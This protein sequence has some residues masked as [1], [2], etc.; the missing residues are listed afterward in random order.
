MFYCVEFGVFR[1]DLMGLGKWCSV[2][3][4]VLHRVGLENVGIILG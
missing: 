3:R 2:K 4:A 1:G